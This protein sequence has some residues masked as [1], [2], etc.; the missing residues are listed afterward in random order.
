MSLVLCATRVSGQ[1]VD[2]FF[3]LH[4]DLCVSELFDSIETHF[5]FEN[6]REREAR[7]AREQSERDVSVKRET[8]ASK[9]SE[10][11]ARSP[12]ERS[13]RVAPQG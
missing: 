12:R 10:M 4:F 1:R 9:A 6:F 11:R 13:D 8:R 7:N 2:F 3:F 5:S